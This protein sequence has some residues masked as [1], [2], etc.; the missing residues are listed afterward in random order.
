MYDYL[1]NTK[2]VFIKFSRIIFEFPPPRRLLNMLGYT[3]LYMVRKND[4]LLN[5]YNIITVLFF[6]M[7]MKSRKK[8]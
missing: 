1:K 4:F 8:S 5:I 3:H 6:I 7:F 2:T